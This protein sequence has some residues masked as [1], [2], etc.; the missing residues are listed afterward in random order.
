MKAFLKR[1]AAC[2]PVSVQQALKRAYFTRQVR[3]QAMIAGDREHELLDQFVSTGD[4]ALDVGANVGAYTTRLSRLVGKSGRVVAFEP[5]VETFELLCSNVR[6]LPDRNVTLFNI[7]ASD[8]SALVNMDVPTLDSGLANYYEA[9]INGS[10]GGVPVLCLPIDQLPLP[11]PVALVKIDAEGHE[12]SVLAGMRR[13]LLRDR[14]KLIV[15]ASTPQV[16]DYLTPLGYDVRR[17]PGSPNYLC[18]PVASTVSA[19]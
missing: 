16:V 9:R 17:Q 14:P 15:E 3:R 12:L 1:I 4:W 13:L 6:N 7:A 18:L 8:Q 10:G 5:V 19:A 11:R 2:L